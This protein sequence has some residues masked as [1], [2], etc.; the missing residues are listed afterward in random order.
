MKITKNVTPCFKRF[1]RQ[2][3][4]KTPI[5]I[6]HSSNPKNAPKYPF[7]TPT[8]PFQKAFLAVGSALAAFGNP[9]RADMVAILGET[10]GGI[11][12]K[13]LQRKM[14][15]DSTGR[16]ILEE[17]P[18]IRDLK[19]DTL[20]SLPENSFGKMYYNFMKERNFKVEERPKVRF[21]DEAELA[22]IMTRYRE[23]HDFW[24]IL[25]GMET[26]VVGEIG[27][28]WVELLQTGLPM[29]YSSIRPLFGAY[30]V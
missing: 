8:T 10:T 4:T 28:K 13:M 15:G 7:H 12:L 9:D 5:Y 27:L 30:S 20:Q 3:C 26:T 16:K 14:K 23:V 1:R 29:T 11:S 19:L 6:N 2:Y 17:Q 22:Y 24:H 21:L 25:F 18:L